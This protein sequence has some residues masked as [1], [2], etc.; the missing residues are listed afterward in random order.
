MKRIPVTSRFCSFA[1]FQTF[2]LVL[3][4]SSDCQLVYRT[5]IADEFA[6]RDLEYNVDT[7]R[8]IFVGEQYH[9]LDLE[10]GIWW[11]GMNYD[12]KGSGLLEFLMEHSAESRAEQL[13]AARG[14]GHNIPKWM[15]GDKYPT[16]VLQPA[17]NV[18]A[19]ANT[20]A[21]ES[22]EPPGLY[23]TTRPHTDDYVGINPVPLVWLLNWDPSTG[24]MYLGTGGAEVSE[25]LDGRVPPGDG[26]NDHDNG[27]RVDI[28]F[29]G[30]FQLSE[31]DKE[32]LKSRFSAVPAVYNKTSA[33]YPFVSSLGVLNQAASAQT[34]LTTTYLVFVC[35]CI[36]PYGPQS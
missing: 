10:D 4:A 13:Q 31:S 21:P 30:L 29:R 12:A 25:Q 32:E 9:G 18:K 17:A 5:R 27:V 8:L 3:L 23:N 2:V 28:S 14:L 34:I 22:S 26:T 20:E 35:L 16:A 11:C 6:W 33:A 15:D 7:G 24:L 19:Y 36:E 1:L